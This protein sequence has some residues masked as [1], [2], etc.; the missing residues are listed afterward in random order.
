MNTEFDGRV[1][2][3]WRLPNGEYKVKLKQNE[4]L[5]FEPDSKITMPA[6]LGSFIL[7]NSER[8]MSIFI[9]EFIGFKTTNVKH[10]DS[11]SL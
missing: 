9:R 5:V 10:T 1:S 2:D 11:D 4:G 3:Y 8:I 6:H 7:S